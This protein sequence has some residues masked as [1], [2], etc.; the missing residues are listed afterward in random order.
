MTSPP[1]FPTYMPAM[2]M[3]DD[4]YLLNEDQRESPDM[5]MR[6]LKRLRSKL[7]SDVKGE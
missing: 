7:K 3:P 6:D 2:T 4:S 1:A 5:A